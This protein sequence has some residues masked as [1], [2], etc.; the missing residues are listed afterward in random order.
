M[1]KYIA[2]IALLIVTVS[3]AYFTTFSSEWAQKP[4]D[5]KPAFEVDPLPPEIEAKRRLQLE[6]SKIQQYGYGQ[7]PVGYPVFEFGAIKLKS[8]GFGRCGA[9]T[10]VPYPG[11]QVLVRAK[12]FKREWFAKDPQP[13]KKFLSPD[14]IEVDQSGLR[15][16]YDRAGSSED[17]YKIFCRIQNLQGTT[18]PVDCSQVL[19]IQSVKQGHCT[20]GPGGVD[21]SYAPLNMSVKNR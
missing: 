5:V 4:I 7:A 9:L 21:A 10:L 6:Q 15:S 14:W 12:R 2:P 1:K 19:T 17:Y 11:L 8:G 18:R 20:W 16:K 3:F 13:E